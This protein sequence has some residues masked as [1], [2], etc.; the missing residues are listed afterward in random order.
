MQITINVPDNL[1]QEVIKKHIL[2]LDE[3]LK[4]LQI[5]EEFKIDEQDITFTNFRTA[6]QRQLFLC[7]V[8]FVQQVTADD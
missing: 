5:V 7:V 4:Q 8:F 1:S 2:E 3:K 6:I